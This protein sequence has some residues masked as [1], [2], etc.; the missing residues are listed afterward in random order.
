[1]HERSTCESH[2]ADPHLATALEGR[3]VANRGKQTWYK[4]VGPQKA[5]SCT[6]CT[7]AKGAHRACSLIVSRT[8]LGKA[9]VRMFVLWCRLSSADLAAHFPFSLYTET[10][11]RAYNLPSKT[12]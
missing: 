4:E 5:V 10:S 12:A 11:P 7:E 9:Y 6:A 2:F 3:Y 8:S 1:M